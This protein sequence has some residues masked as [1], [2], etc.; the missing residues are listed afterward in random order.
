MRYAVGSGALCLLASVAIASPDD[1]IPLS[2]C[3]IPN[4]SQEVLC[5][6]HTVF[7][8]RVRD[9]GRRIQINFAVIPAISEVSESDPVV[10]G[11]LP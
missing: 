9:T 8:D 7:E 6:T 11:R 2:A 5:G 1:G 4:Y 10:P 3:H